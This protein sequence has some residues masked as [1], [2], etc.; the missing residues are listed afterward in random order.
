M[1][2]TIREKQID[3]IKTNLQG[4]AT[5]NATL[6]RL[7]KSGDGICCYS[8]DGCWFISQSDIDQILEEN[9][10]GLIGEVTPDYLCLFNPKMH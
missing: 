1:N 6:N 9:G 10:R 7:S 8:R 3:W 4:G 5:F 2:E